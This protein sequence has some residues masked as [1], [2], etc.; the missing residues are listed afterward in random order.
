MPATLDPALVP[1]AVGAVVVVLLLVAVAGWAA[2]RAD[3]ADALA[4]PDV[5]LLRRRRAPRARR[6]P[7]AAIGAAGSRRLQRALGPRRCAALSHR[8]ELA[9]SPGGDGLEADL[10]RRARL[11]VVFGPGA[12]VL[13]LYGQPLLALLVLAMALALPELALRRAG[14]ARQARLERDLPDFLD[15]LAVTVSAGLGFRTAL[16]RVVER[17]QGPVAQELQRAM[18]QMCLGSSRH[19]A[20]DA[21][22]RRNAAASLEA[23][24]SALLQAEELGS[25]LGEA[26]EQI[27][28]DVRRVAAQ[29]AR[30]RAARTS[31]RITLVVTLVMAP[32][33]MVLLVVGLVLSSGTD[34]GALLG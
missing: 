33:A 1:V 20:F 8:L 12:A 10:A 18:D 26:L 15:V 5:A 34:L 30:R 27:A 25:P 13:L 31:P 29:G 28:R 11:L 21:V 23:F 7:M 2:V 3:P 17:T 14:R 22:R 19:D 16:G 24:V 4:A 6:S 32:G 9:G